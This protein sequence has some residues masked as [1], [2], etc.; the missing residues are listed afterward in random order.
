MR[1]NVFDGKYRSWA[2]KMTPRSS[3]THAPGG[4]YQPIQFKHRKFH[5][6]WIRVNNLN[7][8][9]NA[10]MKKGCYFFWRKNYTCLLAQLYSVLLNLRPEQ[11]RQS[12]L[13][14]PPF[15]LPFGGARV[16]LVFHARGLVCLVLPVNDEWNEEWYTCWSLDTALYF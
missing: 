15:V 12:L 5:Q 16:Q 7:L 13:R 8:D 9:K 3:T 4:Q 1:V 11:L 14:G 6:K 10:I 2:P